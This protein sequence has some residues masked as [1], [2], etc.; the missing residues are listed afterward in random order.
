[1]CGDNKKNGVPQEVLFYDI[2]FMEI[3]REEFTL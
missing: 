3:I 1:M 2:H